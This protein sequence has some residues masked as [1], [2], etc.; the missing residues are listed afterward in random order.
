MSGSGRKALEY[1]LLAKA[2]AVINFHDALLEAGHQVPDKCVPIIDA[3]SS[4]AFALCS[5]PSTMF[6]KRA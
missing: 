5:L 2:D 3:S 6:G 4:P 1:H